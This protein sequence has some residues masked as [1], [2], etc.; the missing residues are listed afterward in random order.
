[1]NHPLFGVTVTAAGSGLWYRVF[2]FSSIVCI[3]GCHLSWFVKGDACPGQG[4]K[5]LA[6][7]FQTGITKSHPL[8]VCMLSKLETQKSAG[9]SISLPSLQWSPA[10]ATY[11]IKRFILVDGSGEISVQDWS[12]PLLWAREGH[13]GGNIFGTSCLHHEPGHGETDHPT[14]LSK[15]ILSKSERYP[16]R[17]LILK[18]HGTSKNSTA[19]GYK[20]LCYK[21]IWEASERNCYM[22]TLRPQ[23]QFS[24]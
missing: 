6:C 5:F 17:L 3:H 21:S 11:E 24:F 15:G 10:S 13:H 7:H 16:T 8:L 4:Q 19:L 14:I 22:S 12:A 20:N 2:N 1:M 18:V 9:N 23:Q